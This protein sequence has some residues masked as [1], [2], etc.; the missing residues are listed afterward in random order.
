MIAEGAHPGAAFNEEF[1]QFVKGLEIKG[2]TQHLPE[3][4]SYLEG[5]AKAINV[6]GDTL[7]P[8]DYYRM[9]KYGRQ[10][11]HNLSEEY[12]TEVAPTLSQEL[13]GSSAG[14][15]HSSFFNAVIGGKMTNRAAATLMKLGLVDKKNVIRTKTGNVKGIKPGGIK[16]ADLAATN[17]FEWVQNVLKPATINHGI[18]D[19]GKQQQ[20]IA[21]LFSNQIVAQL[22]SILLTQGDKIRKDQKLVQASKGLEAATEYQQRDPTTGLLG[23]GRALTSLIEV[24]SNPLMEP[25]AGAMTALA[26]GIAALTEAAKDHPDLALAAGGVATAAGVAG[27]LGLGRGVVALLTAGGSL[28]GSATALTG[29][30]ASLEAAAVALKAGGAPGSSAIEKIAKGGATGTAGGAAAR[31]LGLRGG[32]LLGGEILGALG[33]ISLLLQEAFPTTGQGENYRQKNGGVPFDVYERSRRQDLDR[34]LDP[35]G[36]RG[37]AFQR[38]PDPF[39]EQLGGGPV[40]QQLGSVLSD[41]AAKLAPGQIVSKIDPASKAEVKVRIEVD[42][43]NVTNMSAASSGNIRANVGTGGGSSDGF[44]GLGHR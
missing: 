10:A 33:A 17:P 8:S 28:S 38:L 43:G 11:T 31:A 1:D 29:A 20:T 40:A 4:Q 21:H 32:M 2:V 39:A 18:T 13:G 7:K 15:A 41:I 6:F 30:A 27:A 14:K 16:E 26:K 19:F 44:G 25:A 36:A 22:V 34:R 9:F 24:A 12:M 37:R 23:V 42:G 5:M 3:L 35:E